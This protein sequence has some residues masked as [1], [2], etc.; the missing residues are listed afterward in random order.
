MDASR[1]LTFGVFRLDPAERLLLRDGHPVALTPKAFDLLV[2]LA[3]RPGRLIE[4]PVL[5]AA[6]W[7]DTVVEEANLAYT[8]SALR[9]ALGDGYDG[10]QA[11][12][13]VPTRG[14]RFVANVQEA[15][16]SETPPSP[17]RPRW[18]RVGT[19]A[20][21]LAAG[22]AIGAFVTGA[23]TRLRR[24]DTAPRVV[25]FELPDAVD[26]RHATVPGISPDGRRIAYSDRAGRTRQLFLRSLDDLQ[27]KPI[28][29]TSGGAGN[30]FFSP[31]GRTVGYCVAT[32]AGFRTVD[33]ATGTSTKVITEGCTLTGATWASDGR[34]YFSRFPPSGLGVVP[35]AGGP[36]MSVTTLADGEIS[37]EWP[38]MLPGNRH[39]LFGVRRGVGLDDIDTQVLTIATGERRTILPGGSRAMFVP[40]GHLVYASASSLLA[41]EFD[42]TTLR[43]RGAP[44]PVLAGV[45]VAPL[46]AGTDAAALFNVA[47]T[48]TLVYNGGGVLTDP[49]EIAWRGASTTAANEAVAAPPGLYVDPSVSP[50]GRKLAMA[51]SYGPY[52]QDIWVHDFDRRT[53]TRVTSSPRMD[54]AP[55]WHPLD[56]DRLIYTTVPGGGR[57]S[58]QDLMTIRADGGGPPELLYST[59]RQKYAASSSAAAGLVAFSEVAD[60]F[61][62]WLLDVTGKPTARPFLQTPFHETS[63]ALS[64]DGRW[65]AYDSNESGVQEVYVRPLSGEGK[66]QISP[67]GG[68]RPRWSR[69]GGTIV[70]RRLR[71]WDEPQGP[72]RMMAVTVF[73]KASFAAGNPRVV[74]EGTFSPGGTATPNYDMSDD[75]SRLLLITRLPQHPRLPLIVVENWFAE[76]RQRAGR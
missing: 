10:E 76:L 19:V 62:I 22:A 32:S 71:R 58:G 9:K 17:P 57:E 64:P 59:P 37:H 18:R 33:L 36:T 70:Y 21:L 6:L 72:D 25:R 63:P 47:E 31:D 27:V 23:V 51:P 54:C 5:M 50:D 24:P 69:D 75:G 11:L 55:I 45:A 35:V 68:S 16:S 34:I 67:A 39:L 40:T 7:P 74:A 28:A 26:P 4:K 38:Q 12:Q 48:G 43:V 20:A 52:Q 46:T 41:V 73:T 53:W 8:V 65:I 13:T 60:S 2:Y 14:Y 61:D 29:D 44:R 15:T 56:R 66:W 3:R 42:P 30:P 49:T 1:V